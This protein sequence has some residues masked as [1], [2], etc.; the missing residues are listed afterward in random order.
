[1]IG[2]LYTFSSFPHNILSKKRYTQCI[3][4]I[5]GNILTM[6]GRTILEFPYVQCSLLHI[7]LTLQRHFVLLYH[8]DL[9]QSHH[10]KWLYLFVLVKIFFCPFCI[11][12]FRF[13]A[14]LVCGHS[15][16]GLCLWQFRSGAILVC[17][18]LVCSPF[19]LWPFQFVA[20]FCD[21]LCF[22]R[23]GLWP[24]RSEIHL[25]PTFSTVR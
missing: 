7:S 2:V 24:L 8:C 14:A 16:S 23:F 4:N 6:H 9:V 19:D 18:F 10:I 5:Q 13:V 17:G 22:G 15:E 1:M 21:T 11:W 25:T 20:V 12:Q 3:V